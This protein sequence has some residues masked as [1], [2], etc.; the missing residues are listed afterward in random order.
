MKRIISWFEELLVSIG[1][2]L[3]H[4]CRDN[5]PPHIEVQ[6]FR[7]DPCKNKVIA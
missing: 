1:N 7:D 6:P 3:F 4:P 2:A 5:A